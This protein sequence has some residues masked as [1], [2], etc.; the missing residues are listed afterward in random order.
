MNA[1]AILGRE[2]LVREEFEALALDEFKAITSD[3]LWLTNTALLAEVCDYLGDSIRAKP[4]YDL[5]LPYADRNIVVGRG[6]FWLGS[7]ARCVGI[8]ATLMG[9]YEEA[10]EH[11]DKALEMHR[12][13]QATPWQ[14]QTRFDL[15]RMLLRRG[16]VGDVAAGRRAA[17]RRARPGQGHRDDDAHRPDPGPAAGG[18]RRRSGRQHVDDQLRVAVGAARAAQPAR[19]HA[20]PTARS[21]SCSRTSRARPP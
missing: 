1:H 16:F 17:R 4:L 19:P 20:P 18:P 21:R 14:A 12:R 10:E 8:L 3:Y 15:A 11:F 5:L 13:M 7:V 2:S 6:G 9:R